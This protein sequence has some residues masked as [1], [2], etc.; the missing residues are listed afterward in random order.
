MKCSCS[1]FSRDSFGSPSENGGVFR[2]ASEEHANNARTIHDKTG[3]PDPVKIR[4][5]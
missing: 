3:F 4:K 2:S 5:S 1:G